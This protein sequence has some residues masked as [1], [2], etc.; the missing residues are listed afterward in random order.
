ANDTVFPEKPQIDW[1]KIGELDYENLESWTRFATVAENYL[2][3]AIYPNLLFPFAFPATPF[4]AVRYDGVIQLLLAQNQ[5]VIKD[6]AEGMRRTL[7]LV[8]DDHWMSR[9]LPGPFEQLI[10]DKFGAN[11][12]EA[13]P[14]EFKPVDRTVLQE[15]TVAESVSLLEQPESV[16]YPVL[17]NYFELVERA[18]NTFNRRGLRIEADELAALQ[19]SG[20]VPTLEDLPGNWTV[21]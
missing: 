12:F 8:T 14:L 19:T 2:K 17:K 7:E 9:Q 6:L 18:A 3:V 1:A 4:F 10:R 13:F 11:L 16:A 15:Q 5:I 20:A 21:E